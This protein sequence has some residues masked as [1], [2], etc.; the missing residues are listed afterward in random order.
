MQ[1][2]ASYF[3]IIAERV[4][5]FAEGAE[6]RIYKDSVAGFGY[7]RR[8]GFISYQGLRY[9]YFQA[10]PFAV[11][12][13]VAYLA[14][15]NLIITRELLTCQLDPSG[16]ARRFIKE[17]RSVRRRALSNVYRGERRRRRRL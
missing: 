4:T 6:K 7:G 12:R 11:F 2:P 17:I 13:L 3:R 5:G 8:G 16:E 9:S 1:S 15:L 14:W 10:K